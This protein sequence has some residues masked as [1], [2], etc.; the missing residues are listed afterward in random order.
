M[1][2][3]PH[4]RFLLVTTSF[5]ILL[6]FG[7]WAYRPWQLGAENGR[8][9][10]T[11]T[12]W[13]R[14]NPGG[15]GAFGAVGAG[16]SGIILVGSD[17]SGAYRSLDG[18]QHWD[19]IGSYRGL[20]TTHINSVGFDPADDHILYLGSDNGIFRSNNQGET[21]SHVLEGGYISAI[22]I[23]PTTPTIGY[24]AHHSYYEGTDGTVYK[25]TDRGQSWHPLSTNLFHP[26]R[27]L[28]LVLHPDDPN[29]L[30]L[31]GGEARFGCSPPALYRSQ[32]GGTSWQRLAGTVGQIQDVALAPA[33]PNIL[34]ITTYDE[35][36]EGAG[37]RCLTNDPD[38]GKLYKSED[39]G[40][41]WA[42]IAQRTGAIWLDRD[43]PQAVRLID[44]QFQ[45]PW[46]PERT[47]VWETLDDG[48]TWEQVGLAQDSEQSYWDK[49]WPT[50]W[51]TYGA[52]F[53]GPAHTLGE[54][55][56]DPDALLWVT[57]QFVFASR[58][59]GR[60]FVNLYTNEVAPGRWQS[61][62]VD[63]TVMFSV[64]V[65]PA[66]PDHI[67]TGFYDLGCF[68]SPDNGVSWQSCNDPAYTGGWEGDGGN[69]TTILADPARTGVVWASQTENLEN[70]HTLLWSEDYGQSW[71]R[72]D[73]G[74]PAGPLSGLSLAASS[75]ADNRTLFVSASRDVYRSEDDGATWEMVLDCEG[76]WFTAV[77]PFAANFVYAGG[78]AGLF[79]SEQGGAV[80]SW[81]AVSHP[82]FTGSGQNPWGWDYEWTGIHALRPDP[83]HPDRLYAAVWGEGRGLYVSQDRGASWD[84]LL[85]DDYLRDIAIA[86]DALYA[87]SSKAS[88][89][90]AS[91][92]HSNGIRRS[93]DGG[94][95]WETVNDGLAWP[96]AGPITLDPRNPAR[97]I[98]G[99]YGTGFAIREFGTSLTEY[100]PLIKR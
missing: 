80:G 23:H 38:G 92:L 29:T 56:S 93:Q 68:H 99:A 51:W 2:T 87:T 60:D 16:P 74:L 85:T 94:Q 73:A 12:P 47:G 31:L 40:D 25:T 6:G 17:L 27:I 22:Q 89:C 76:C 63:N 43:D 37:F 24:A 14:T 62:G 4:T 5:L 26:L 97:V 86:P 44:L 100:L 84:K 55:M 96:F 90:G 53:D 79:R 33:N 36:W 61:R 28:K 15:G 71:E 50:L 64:S 18:G 1:P 21:V 7:L 9:S 19:V 30:Y 95:T 10:L 72:R 3:Y 77:N 49:G 91:T 11:P 41:S 58:N 48:L 35:V 8:F 13:Q 45:N 83:Y 88:C 20:T 67:Y 42:E 66:A 78:E 70:A 98:V 82:D 52:N 34:Y 69:T 65:S 39:A 46:V 57:N 75:P 54:D 59:D 32:N 81:T